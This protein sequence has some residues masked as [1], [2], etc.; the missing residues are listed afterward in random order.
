MAKALEQVRQ[1][2]T[3]FC[4]QL[5]HIR[6]GQ[7]KLKTYIS[8]AKTEL[9]KYNSVSEKIVFKSK[10]RKNAINEKDSLPFWN[11]PKKKKLT[12][13]IAELTELLEELRSERAAILKY[14]QYEDGM[15]IS[16]VEKDIAKSEEN[17]KRLDKYE[18]KFAAELNSAF[19]QYAQLKNEAS[20]FDEVELYKA[21]QALR[22]DCEN[23]AVKSLQRLYG[24]KYNPRLMA[25][26]KREA[27][28][29][30]D[31]A[32]EARSVRERLRQRQCGKD[33]EP[34]CTLP[35]WKSRGA[36]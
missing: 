36:R 30:L 13:R 34:P 27:V 12:A 21:R 17:L 15:D 3:V 8:S 28:K 20:E 9:E 5:G 25:E 32:A 2:V 11:I 4:Y 19:K 26:S 35:K 18:E 31:E 16:D 14:L 24:E 29:L 22:Y 23:T 6:S 7:K 33:K 1:N 10:E